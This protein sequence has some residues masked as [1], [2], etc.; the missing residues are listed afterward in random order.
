M[1][2]HHLIKIGNE[3]F[4]Y[5]ANMQF[6]CTKITGLGIMKF[7]YYCIFSLTAFR[8][9]HQRCNAFY[10][11]QVIQTHDSTKNYP[12]GHCGTTQNIY[13]ERFEN[14]DVKEEIL[15]NNINKTFLSLQFNYNKTMR[16]QSRIIAKNC[17][18]S[19][20]FV[21]SFFYMND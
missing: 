10:Y 20:N 14:I 2:S 15:A 13:I 9:N 3:H 21:G 17:D 5:I 16:C 11:I 8:A 12:W 7:S 18:I 6:P 19:R 4:P 1:F